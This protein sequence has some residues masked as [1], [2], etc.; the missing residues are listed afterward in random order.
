MTSIA[1]NANAAFAALIAGL[2]AIHVELARPGLI[3]P[4]ALGAL[5]A[6]VALFALPVSG[7]G[8]AM[9]LAAAAL[10][11]VEGRFPARGIAGMLGACELTLA[12]L[13]MR[14]H[15]AVAL[16]LALPFSFFT[17]RRLKLVFLARRNKRER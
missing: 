16:A 13:E 6:V 15:P 12:A 2:F 9:L 4:G 3:L 10:F 1:I 17:A 7:A 5:L 8:A 11:A 14:V